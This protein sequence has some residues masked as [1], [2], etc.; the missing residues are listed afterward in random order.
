M[1]TSIEILS[2]IRKMSTKTLNPLH[3][4]LVGDIA[5]EMAISQDA[6]LVLLI[7]L[8]NRGLVKIYKT[9]IASISLTNYG[10]QESPPS[11]LSS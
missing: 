5:A 9:K 10:N 6:L 3:R 1:I 4:I 7:E 8:E 2:K 11:G